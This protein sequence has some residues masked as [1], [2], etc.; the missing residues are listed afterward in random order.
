MI[1]RPH[2]QA[3]FTLPELIVALAISAILLGLALPSFR[4]LMG[5]SKMTTTTN[6]LALSRLPKM[7]VVAAAILAMAG[8]C[9]WMKIRMVTTMRMNLWSCK[10]QAPDTV[11]SSGLE[12]P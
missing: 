12:L 9:M 7:P 5:D 6:S 2:G 4:S 3:G 1:D 8:W 10:L 11:L